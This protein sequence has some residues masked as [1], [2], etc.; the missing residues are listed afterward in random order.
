LALPWVFQYHSTEGIFEL[1]S[2]DAA[3]YLI[4]VNCFR[5]VNCIPRYVP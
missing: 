2:I 3:L 4:H 1:V 5:D